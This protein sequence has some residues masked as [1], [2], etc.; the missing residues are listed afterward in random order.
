MNIEDGHDH[1][2]DQIQILQNDEQVEIAVVSDTDTIV[3]PLTMMVIAFHTLIACV[4]VTRVGGTYHFA[5]RAEQVCLKFLDESHERY[6]WFALHV[7]RVNANSEDKEYH[8]TAE[9]H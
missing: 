2:Q 4:A 5:V 1:H 8:C 6:L 9:N 3:D 7:A